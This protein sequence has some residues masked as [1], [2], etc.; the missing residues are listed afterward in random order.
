[1]A[2]FIAFFDESGS[3]A[4][5]VVVVAGFVAAVEQWV[6]FERNWKDLLNAFNVSSL[7]MRQFAHSRGEFTDWVGDERKRRR[8][9]ERAVNIICTRVR[10]TFASAVMMDE[11]RKVDAEYCLSEFSKP[12]AL[13]GCTCVNKVRKWGQKY[14]TKDDT[15]A[16]VFEDGADGKGQVMSS[17]KKEF[18]HTATFLKKDRHLA[19][20][21]ADLL[22]Y[23]HLSANKKAQKYGIGMVG[24][25]DL[26]RPLQALSRIP[27]AH[28]EDWGAHMEDDM[29]DSCARDGIA[30]RR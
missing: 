15:I 10:H 11:Y 30:L 19:F 12:Y 27:G 9:L 18:G 17:V 16:F 14:M 6:E 28:T 5:Q 7:H 29:M 13:A 25:E 2:K 21:A 23:E 3:P 8:F 26:R 22:A 4:E 1:M 20:Q 24:F